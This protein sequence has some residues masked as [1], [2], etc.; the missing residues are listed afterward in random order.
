MIQTISCRLFFVTQLAQTWMIFSIFMIVLFYLFLGCFPGINEG[1]S[2][3]NPSRI[4]KMLIKELSS[5]HG[6]SISAWLQYF[7][8]SLPLT[9]RSYCNEVCYFYRFQGEYIAVYQGVIHLCLALR[10]RCGCLQDSYDF[11]WRLTNQG[12]C[13]YYCGWNEETC[14]L[15]EGVKAQDLWKPSS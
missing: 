6:V 4:Y 3:G 7:F 9:N 11:C 15:S 2:E 14:F 10:R 13:S 1:Q 5:S 8:Y 12:L